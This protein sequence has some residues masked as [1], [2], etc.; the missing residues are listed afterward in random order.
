MVRAPPALQAV[1]DAFALDRFKPC[2]LRNGAFWSFRPALLAQA[3]KRIAAATETWSALAGGNRN[4][5]KP[6]ADQF[7][8]VCDSL[9][10]L[11]PGSESLAVALTKTLDAIT[12]TGEPPSAA[13]AMEV[14][15]SVLYLQAAFEELDA[16]DDQMISG[17][18]VWPSG[19]MRWDRVQSL[20]LWKPGWKSCTA[21]SATTRRWA[22]WWMSCAP[23][24]LRP[25]RRWI[26]FPQPARNLAAGGRTRLLGANAWGTVCAGIGSGISGGAAH[27][28]HG[29]ASAHQ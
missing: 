24:S 6:A 22:A 26:S 13:L 14:A 5:I 3:R 23:P 1:R 20:S 2:G 29:G 18:P 10:K 25:K 16:A 11:N 19:W 7:S 21:V 17:R 8:L 27:A 4:K 12:R 9:R 15:T 28:R